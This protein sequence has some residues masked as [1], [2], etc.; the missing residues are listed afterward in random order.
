MRGFEIPYDEENESEE[1]EEIGP[2]LFP[3]KRG[4]HEVAGNSQGSAGG[5]SAKGP[6]LPE[7]KKKAGLQSGFFGSM[8]AVG[9]NAGDN[10]KSEQKQG[11]Q[12]NPQPFK[13]SR[14]APGSAEDD[15]DDDGSLPSLVTGIHYRAQLLHL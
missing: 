7:R 12:S 1:A 4:K 14:K 3:S 8:G 2:M 6:K 5:P 11:A 10:R 15:D 9:S 13:T